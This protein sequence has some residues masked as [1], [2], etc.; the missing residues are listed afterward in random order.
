[1]THAREE[2]TISIREVI[3]FRGDLIEVAAETALPPGSRVRLVLLE[4]AAQQELTLAGKV[5]G[6]E[7]AGAGG[8]A[9]RVRLHSLPRDQREALEALVSKPTGI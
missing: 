6:I 3:A 9:L 4:T 7:R 2:R 8:Y 1:M 5:V